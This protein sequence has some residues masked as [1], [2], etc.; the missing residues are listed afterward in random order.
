[1]EAAI[2]IGSKRNTRPSIGGPSGLTC[3]FH[4]EAP[5]HVGTE[6]WRSVVMAERLPKSQALTGAIP[7]VRSK[8]VPDR[9][10]F[11]MVWNIHV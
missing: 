3:R 2:Q 4:L 11:L 8:P 5:G 6:E 7:K 9:G 1:M 10:F